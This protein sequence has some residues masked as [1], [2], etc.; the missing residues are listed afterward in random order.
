MKRLSLGEWGLR[1][2]WGEIFSPR[3]KRVSAQ[4]PASVLD[5]LIA[6]QGRR[7]VFGSKGRRLKARTGLSE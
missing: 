3:E 5:G 2:L 1:S 7:W 4:C 6:P